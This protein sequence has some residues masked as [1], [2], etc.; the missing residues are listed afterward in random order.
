M[1]GLL[2]VEGAEAF[3]TDTGRDWYTADIQTS[4]QIFA[5]LAVERAPLVRTICKALQNSDDGTL[6]DDFFRDL[7]RRGYSEDY[8]ETPTRHR[9]RLGPLRRTVRLRRRHPRT[10]RSPRSTPPSDPSWKA[11]PRVTTS[12]GQPRPSLRLII[13]IS[14]LRHGEVSRTR[15]GG[16]R[17]CRRE[18]VER[19]ADELTR[20][21]RPA[22]RR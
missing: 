21:P 16:L 7:L 6:R 2:E 4:K 22:D 1:L 18:L 17:A 5:R 14:R 13:A 9:H 15:R 19:L 8:T 11:G 12:T 10:R 3:L 20:R